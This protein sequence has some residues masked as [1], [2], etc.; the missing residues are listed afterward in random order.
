LTLKLQVDYK[1]N[2]LDHDNV[3]V[4]S[5]III[6]TGF[7]KPGVAIQDCIV[8]RLLVIPE[9]VKSIFCKIS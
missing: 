3:Q 6:R 7:G 9:K 5:L 4:L 2:P 1:H 8:L